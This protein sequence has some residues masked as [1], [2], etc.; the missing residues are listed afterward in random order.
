MVGPTLESCDAIDVGHPAVQ[1]YQI[2]LACVVCR[3]GLHC[4]TRDGDPITFVI[5]NISHNLADVGLIVN[6]KYVFCVQVIFNGMRR[7]L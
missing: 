6:D 4:I 3:L 2:G 1:E 5:E 7:C